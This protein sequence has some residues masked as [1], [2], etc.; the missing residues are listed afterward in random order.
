MPRS[1][2]DHE[3]HR[4]RPAGH[5][6]ARD[7]AGPHPHASGAGG[8]AGRRPRRRHRRLVRRAADAPR[9]VLRPAAVPVRPRL[10]PGRRRRAI[11]RGRPGGRAARR[12]AD[13]DRRL[14]RAASSSTRPTSCRCPTGVDPVAAETV[15]VNGVTAWRMLHRAAKVRAGSDRSS[16]SAP[17]AASAPRSSSSPATRASASSAPPARGSTSALRELGAIPVDY[18]NEDVPARVREIA[19]DGVDAV[20]DHVGGPGIADSW[21]M[22]AT[23]GTLVSYGTASTR[24]DARQPAPPGAQAARPGC[25]LEPAAERGRATSSTSGPAAGCARRG[26]RAELRQDLTAV[27]RLLADGAITAQV[28]RGRSRS[29]TPRRRC[30][31]PRPA[32]SPGRSCSCRSRRSTDRESVTARAR[33]TV[34]PSASTA[35]NS[36]A[37]RRPWLRPRS[38]MW[39]GHISLTASW[40]RT[41]IRARLPHRTHGRIH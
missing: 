3:R 28:A 21:R 19:P 2:N 26:I 37:P 10:R 36:R 41:T 31:S 9:Q 34:D 16:C 24:D 8:R 39:L 20:F 15:V 11:G 22:L 23:G 27:L 29:P 32:P 7:A 14:G 18:R 5:R 40:P 30:A 25:G 4:D 6:R 38:V 13:E 35:R 17:T 12:R 1:A 33:R